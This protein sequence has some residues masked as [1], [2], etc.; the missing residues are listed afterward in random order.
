MLL[1]LGHPGALSWA[2][3]A[4]PPNI[5][6]GKTIRSPLRDAVVPEMGEV[7]AGN[8]HLSQHSEIFS[9]NQ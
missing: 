7:S 4:A 1:S 8:R 3:E 9:T 5:N 2:W 6:E